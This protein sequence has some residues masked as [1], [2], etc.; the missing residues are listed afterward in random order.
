[1]AGPATLVTGDTD[2]FV[3]CFVKDVRTGQIVRVDTDAA[4]SI[5]NDGMPCTRGYD[6]S[7]DSCQIVFWRFASDL[8][9][10]DTNKLPDLFMTANPF[11]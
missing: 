3:D 2:G 1:M 11:A 9:P 7:S 10:G 8:V 6:F 4:G 5:G